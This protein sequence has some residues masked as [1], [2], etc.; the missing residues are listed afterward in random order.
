MREK[1]NATFSSSPGLSRPEAQP[2]RAA[3]ASRPALPQ[4]ASAP[5]HPPA[6]R[7]LPSRPR[8]C[9]VT[10]VSK[11]AL[12]GLLRQSWARAETLTCFKGI[13]SCPG[14]KGS[15]LPAESTANTSTRTEMSL[16]VP[17]QGFR[18]LLPPTQPM[19]HTAD[20]EQP[21]KGQAQG[22]GPQHSNPEPPLLSGVGAGQI[23]GGREGSPGIQTTAAKRQARGT[24][25][26]GALPEPP[27]Q[28]RRQQPAPHTALA[29]GVRLA[30]AGRREKQNKTKN[31]NR[32]KPNPRGMQCDNPKL[33]GPPGRRVEELGLQRS[34]Q[35]SGHSS[36]HVTLQF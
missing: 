4:L 22:R 30:S 19:V 23:K 1:K 26:G 16:P 11:L 32:N 2:L 31:N 21:K 15:P 33:E 5:A 10:Q 24:A 27:G 25:A 14:G 28:L 18:L 12:C 7:P 6:P 3:A 17:A 13:W 29:L 20:G 8:S 34:Q 9:G 36:L 35:L